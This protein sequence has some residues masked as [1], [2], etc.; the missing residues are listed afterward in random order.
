MIH[1]LKGFCEQV[2][3]ALVA[4]QPREQSTILC[5]RSFP[6][7]RIQ[8]EVLAALRLLDAADGLIQKDGKL[9]NL[10]LTEGDGRS[11]AWKM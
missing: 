1:T 9:A 5:P 8:F 3:F 4:K 11:L 10:V 7:V 6:C 2:V